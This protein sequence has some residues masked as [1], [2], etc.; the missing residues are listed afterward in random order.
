MRMWTAGV[1][2]WVWGCSGGENRPANRTCVRPSRPP[3]PSR[4]VWWWGALML[5][6]PPC[7]VNTSSRMRTFELLTSTKTKLTFPSQPKP[8]KLQPC[9]LTW[10]LKRILQQFK[11]KRLLLLW[12]TK[13][14]GT[15]YLKEFRNVEDTPYL[16]QKKIVPF[17]SQ[18]LDTLHFTVL[19]G[20]IEARLHRKKSMI[21]WRLPPRC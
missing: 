4:S 10:R 13:I 19:E 11:A 20:S 7:D 15:P 3:R 17:T 8:K 16:L 12:F 2:G 14:F 21:I 1:T 9:D 18:V 5:V 6:I